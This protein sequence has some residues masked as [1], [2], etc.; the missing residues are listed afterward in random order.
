MISSEGLGVRREKKAQTQ[1][2]QARK[3]LMLYCLL[4]YILSKG[5]RK[6]LFLCLVWRKE[7]CHN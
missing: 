2:S 4:L 6:K 1:G 5:C 3:K 7:V